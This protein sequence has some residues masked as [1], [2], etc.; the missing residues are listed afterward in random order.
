MTLI[1]ETVIQLICEALYNCDK[2]KFYNYAFLQVVNSY[3]ED[4]TVA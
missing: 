4:L 2:S 3:I 1:T